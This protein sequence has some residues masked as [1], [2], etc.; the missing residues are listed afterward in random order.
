MEQKGIN[1]NDFP[2]HLKRGTCVIK[3]EQYGESNELENIS[4]G[5]NHWII[6]TEIPQFKGEG[7]EYIE[8]LIMVGEV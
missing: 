8:K 4:V 3:L 7:R 1:W 2:T 5:K 6:D